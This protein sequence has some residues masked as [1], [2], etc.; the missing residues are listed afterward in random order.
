MRFYNRIGLHHF[1]DRRMGDDLGRLSG[2]CH[3]SQHSMGGGHRGDRTMSI[4]D[5]I[6]IGVLIVL[7]GFAVTAVSGGEFKL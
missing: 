7:G 2:V 5:Y 4:F 1:W 3:N 6:A